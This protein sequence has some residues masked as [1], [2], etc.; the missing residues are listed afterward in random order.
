M[1]IILPWPPAELSPNY[2]H[3]W[4]SKHSSKV[5]YR[6]DCFYIA[7][8]QNISFGKTINIP[9]KITFHPKTKRSPDLDNCLSWCKHGLDSVAKA[10]GIND[11]QF[12]PITIQRGEPVK[13]GS[14]VVEA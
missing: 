3:G 5:K 2:R 8:S 12:N 11:Q 4:Q 13:N 1:K 10:W 6:N 14:V 7:K 9:L